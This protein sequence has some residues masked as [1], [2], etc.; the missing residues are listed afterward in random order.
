M[1]K[2]V[3]SA[4]VT[5]GALLLFT[6]SAYAQNSATV[7]V[8]VQVANR[9]LL[10]LDA[11]AITFADQDPD[12]VP[13]LT[14]PALNITARARATAGSSVSLTV[15]ATGDLDSGTATIPIGSLTWTATGTGFV[16]GASSTTAQSLGSWIGSGLRSGTQTYSLPNSW[17][18]ATGTYTTTLTYTLAVP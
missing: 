11:N 8:S 7:N 13:T 10:T 15:V 1:K 5:A 16:A 17:D 12:T 2:A 4:I 3:W 6:T 14:A 18:Y 9:A